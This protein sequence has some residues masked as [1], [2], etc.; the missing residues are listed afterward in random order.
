MNE[1]PKSNKLRKLLL[2]LVALVGCCVLCY[3]GSIFLTPVAMPLLAQQVEMFAPAVTLPAEEPPASEAGPT[4]DLG[5]DFFA[6]F[7]TTT[8]T[9]PPTPTIPP[10]PSSTPTV[11]VPS[12]TPT[13]PLPP[14]ASCVPQGERVRALV[15][16]ILSGDM[17]Q[18][19][20]REQTYTVKYIGVRSP[21]LGLESEPYAL[22]A[23]LANQSLVQNQVVTLMK[24]ASEMDADGMSLL[25]YVFVND[26]FVNY[27]MV[28]RG[29]AVAASNPPNTACDEQFQLAQQAAIESG[30]G[31]WE[32]GGP[33][34]QPEA[35]PSEAAP[36]AEQTVVAAEPCNCKGPDLQCDDF[37]TR[38]DAQACFDACKAQGLGDIFL[39]DSNGNGIACED[40]RP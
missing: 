4:A 22:E 26:V 34:S 15:T 39:M 35:P 8:P 40:K 23:A 17:I 27:D 7:E 12:A 30:V 18:V 13:Q 2:I 9:L 19:V 16:K 21:A 11:F 20:I 1:K 3:A 14:S 5:T 32:E 28:S 36:A 6:P 31:M 33:Q 29:M 37:A 38:A 10:T 25:R 24:D